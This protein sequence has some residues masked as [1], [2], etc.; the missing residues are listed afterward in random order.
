MV[1]RKLVKIKLSNG[2]LEWTTK[3]LTQI[4]VPF[5]PMTV[6]EF[7]ESDSVINFTIKSLAMSIAFPLASVK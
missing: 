6:R 4:A 3:T 1:K 7:L 5:A 2:P